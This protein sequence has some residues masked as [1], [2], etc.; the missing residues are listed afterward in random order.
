M[1]GLLFYNIQQKYWFSIFVLNIFISIAS[2]MSCND[3][4][5]N[6]QWGFSRGLSQGTL[7]LPVR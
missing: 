2:C 3:L 1:T 7:G 6:L 5:N 4:C